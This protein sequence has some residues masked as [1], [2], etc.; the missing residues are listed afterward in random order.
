MLCRVTIRRCLCVSPQKRRTGAAT[1]LVEWCEA[2][3]AAAASN[4]GASAAEVWLAVQEENGAARR[5]P[6]AEREL[7]SDAV[8]SSTCALHLINF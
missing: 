8:N 2:E 1:A 4:C 3:A 7:Q 6:G 5:L